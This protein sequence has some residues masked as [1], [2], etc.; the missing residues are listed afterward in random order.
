[1]FPTSEGALHVAAIRNQCHRGIVGWAMDSHAGAELVVDAI[2][3]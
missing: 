3:M 2:T 1:M